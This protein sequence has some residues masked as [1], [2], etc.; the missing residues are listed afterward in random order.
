MSTDRL[1]AL[2]GATLG[3]RSW[4]DKAAPR[5]VHRHQRYMHKHAPAGDKP[6]DRRGLIVDIFDSSRVERDR[7]RSPNPVPAGERWHTPHATC[8]PSPRCRS[9]SWSPRHGRAAPG[10]PARRLHRPGGGSRTSAA[11]CAARPRVVTPAPSAAL[12]ST[13]QADCRDSLPPREFKNMAAPDLP[14]AASS[15][16][17]RTR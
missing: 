3:G 17:A 12:F 7:R 4:P 16:R 13:A 14:A 15:G 1:V 10:P 8:R 11:A 9:G 5:S 2:A 6:V